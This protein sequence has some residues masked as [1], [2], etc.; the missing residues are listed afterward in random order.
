L[1]ELLNKISYFYSILQN[2]QYQALRNDYAY[3]LYRKTG[4]HTYRAGG[5]IFWATTVSVSD[6]GCLILQ[7][8][9]GTM[10]QYRFK[11]VEFVFD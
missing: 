9:D 8:E 1:N 4:V 10:A 5:I 11:E 2:Q 3:M 6:A 7:Q